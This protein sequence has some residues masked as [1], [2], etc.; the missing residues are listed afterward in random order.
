[1]GAKFFYNRHDGVSSC[2]L[3]LQKHATKWNALSGGLCSIGLVQYRPGN[4]IDSQILSWEWKVE[5]KYIK[6]HSCF[7]AMEN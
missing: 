4:G 3:Q 5:L 2:V 6:P 1:M 7:V